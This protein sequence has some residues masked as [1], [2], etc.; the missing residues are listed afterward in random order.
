MT[1]L[2]KLISRYRE[3]PNCESSVLLLIREVLVCVQYSYKC[4]MS[5][6]DVITQIETRYATA[7]ELLKQGCFRWTACIG[8][9]KCRN[10][11]RSVAN[12]LRVNA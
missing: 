4:L 1:R 6:N 8:S 12:S 9:L 5:T 3:A 11:A 10:C 2:S 7:K